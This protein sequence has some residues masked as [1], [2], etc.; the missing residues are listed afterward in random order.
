MQ[1]EL[2]VL[3][4][5]DLQEVLQYFWDQILSLG[6]RENKQLCQDLAQKQSIKHWQMQLQK[7][8]GF[9]LYC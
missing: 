5:D 7:S 4:T 3:M 1:I 2:E 6:M 9:K 8:C